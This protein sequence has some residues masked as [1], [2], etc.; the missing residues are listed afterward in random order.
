MLGTQGIGV[1]EYDAVKLEPLGLLGAHDRDRCIQSLVVETEV[2]STEKRSQLCQAIIGRYHRVSPLAR[3]RCLDLR[4][5]IPH[6]HG[7]SHYGRAVSNG[8]QDRRLPTSRDQ[9]CG[10]SFGDLSGDAVG[11]LQGVTVHLAFAPVQSL[12]PR[13][14]TG[15]VGRLL[16]IA[17][18][19]HGLA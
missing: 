1:E 18:D 2:R 10:G 9:Q 5:E 7:L 17:H 13:T 11:H 6:P 19:R 4:G 15:R 3:A 16:E 14:W 8:R 12:V